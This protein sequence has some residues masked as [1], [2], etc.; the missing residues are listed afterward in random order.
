MN[1]ADDNTPYAMKNTT[2]EVIKQLEKRTNSLLQWI[3]QKF[4]KANSNK[5]HLLLSDSVAKVVKI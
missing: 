4:L 3:S 1:Y 2:E 5:S